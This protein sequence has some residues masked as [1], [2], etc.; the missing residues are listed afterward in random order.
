MR[1]DE[2]DEYEMEHHVS[3]ISLGL[4]SLSLCNVSMS[5]VNMSVH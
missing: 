2:Y 5:L 1:S 4:L 3:A